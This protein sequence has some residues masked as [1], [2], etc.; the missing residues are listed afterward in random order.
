MVRANRRHAP[1]QL[2]PGHRRKRAGLGDQLFGRSAVRRNDAAKRPNIAQMANERARIE[3]P[4][5]RNAMALQIGVRRLARAPIRRQ[6]RKFAHHQRFD[7]RLAGLFVVVIRADVADVRIRQRDDLPAITGI[8]EYFLVTRQAGVENN[9]AATTG[10]STRRAAAKD[11]AVFQRES[12]ADC[13]DF[14]Q[15]V[16]LKSSFRCRVHGRRRSQ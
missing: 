6:R 13:R 10:A 15:C 11:S 16:L 12:R 8:G 1:R 7:V 9:F 5:H 14:V 3:I 2:L 4:N